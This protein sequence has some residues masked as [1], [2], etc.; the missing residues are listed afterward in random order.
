MEKKTGEIIVPTEPTNP[1]AKVTGFTFKSYDKKAGLL[2]FEIKNQDG[3]PTDLINATVRLFMY[4]Y[5]GEEKKEFPIFDNQIITESYM[6]GIVKYLIPDMLLAYEGKVD[7]NVYIDFPDG[8]H[9]DNLAFT[10]NIE[11]S[12]IDRDVQ[13]NGE[14]YFKDFQQLLDGIK[15]ET[16]D[17]V[18]EALTNVDSTIEKA[19]QQINNFVENAAQSIDQNVVEVTEELKTTQSNIDTVSQN[20]VST[21]NELTLIKDK[22]NQ[23]NQQIG[24]LGKLK[25]MY[26]NSIDFGGYDYSGNPNLMANINADSFS[27][28]TGAL[29][30]VD[31][32][33]EVVVTLDPN[34]KLEIYKMKS[35][36][37]LIV[38]KTYT[39]SVEIMLEDD[40][41]G[42][43]SKIVLRYF[44]MPQWVPA[45]TTPNTLTTAKGVWQKLTVTAKMTTAIDNAESWYILL[46]N[47]D[48]NNSLSGRLRLRH[49]KLEEGS[50][51]TPY[52][53]NLLDDPYWLG[54]APLGE[55]I[56]NKDVQF[57][58]TTTEYSVYSK[59][60]VEDY[61]VNQKYVL[62][63][64]A[65]KPATQRFI[66]YLNGGTIKAAVLYPVEGLTDTWQGEFTVTQA[67]ID[68]GALRTLA[69]YQFPSETK[70]TVKIDW[71]KIEKGDT[72]TPN[73]SQFKYF[74]EGL[75]DSDNP[76][77][78]SWNITPDY[79]EQYFVTKSST[80]KGLMVYKNQYIT[81]E[82][83]DDIQESG[84]YYCAGATGENMPVQGPLYGNLIVIKSAGVIIQQF[85]S[86]GMFYKRAM[87]GYPM[88]WNPWS[89]LASDA[90]VVHSSGNESIDGF[91]DF[92]QTP[93]V[94]N[95]PVALDRFVSK[96][97][98]T[99]NTTD[100]TNES[101]VRFERD[102]RSVVANFSI[103]N[104]SANFA[105]WKN[106][107]AFPKGY[108]P[109][110]LKDW[111]GT[112]ANKTNRN[113]ALSVYANGSGIVVMVSTTNLPEN[114]ECSG[115]VSY[116][117][118]DVWPNE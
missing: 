9:T 44:R 67:S 6:Q 23:T 15:Q 90:S 36:P 115:T 105:G 77:D 117:T 114:Q 47:Q 34:H 66:A 89:K 74:G 8:S 26:S 51:A 12:I 17:A 31:D 4:I 11:K 98:K 86:N 96:T 42:D 7:A 103:T 22:M 58:I 85:L 46:Y 3:S 93:T 116:F 87:I 92:R 83:W 79:G 33:D 60:N 38:G 62:T 101:S 111:G 21:Q 25:K 27:Q 69:V 109:T 108:T 35:Q 99:T 13:L 40:F 16:T 82:N 112:L 91:K 81:T 102:G 14:Y 32:G 78:Y 49:A 41:T 28:G 5:S 75:K 19:N 1:P 63:M 2:Q 43:P 118:N 20:V 65:T 29:S 18:N 88:A 55:N 64:K 72:R 10:F 52:Q 61:K 68:A 95:V 100:F 70:G 84:I 76:N 107:M 80:E 45:L 97:V 30:V 54:K 57:P 94:N 59:A 50:T 37:A 48:A 56:A 106:L 24:D 104:K 73:I 53:P 113:P 110:S 71:L 39:M